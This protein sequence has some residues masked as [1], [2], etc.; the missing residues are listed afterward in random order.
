MKGSKKTLLAIPLLMLLIAA[1]CQ[2]GGPGGSITADGSS[3]V[4]PITQG[5]AED[6]RAEAPD[7]QV[8]VGTSGTGGGFQKFCSGETDI[9]DASRPIK[10]SEAAVCAQNGVKYVELQ[11]AIDGLSVLVN[12]TNTWTQCLTTEELKRIWETNST[13]KNWSEVRAGFPNRFLT[14]YG[15]GTDSGSFDYFTA[16]IVGEE[17][18]SRSDYTA[19]EDDNVLVRGIAGDENALGYFGFAYY[20]QNTD[21]LKAVAVDAGAGCVAPTRQTIDSGDYS[22]L[23]RPLFIYVAEKATARP[24]VKAFVDFYLENVNEIAQD[25]GYIAVPADVLEKETAEW[26]AFAS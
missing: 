8:A 4:F 11:I 6:F 23:S 2:A 14:L 16:E 5:I 7:V 18:A 12:P 9:S 13:I 19:S 15:P 17:G 20:E 1:G 26:N 22:P 24:E 10:E 21:K 3:T 25:V